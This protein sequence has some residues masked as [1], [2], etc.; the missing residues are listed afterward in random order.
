MNML[1]SLDNM[2]KVKMKGMLVTAGVSVSPKQD[3]PPQSPEVVHSVT[4]S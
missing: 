2:L 4:I 1:D 3:T